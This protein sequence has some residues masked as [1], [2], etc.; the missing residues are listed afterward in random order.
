LENAQK[1]DPNSPETLLGLGYFQYMV[2]R[3]VTLA[4]TTFERVSKMLPG[5]IEV[6][7]ALANVARAEGHWDQSIAYF[8][9]A[10]ALDPR[11]VEL[12][13]RAT[14]N[15]AILRQFPAALKLLDRVLDITPNDLDVMA[16]K[17]SIYHAQGNL[18]EAAKLLSGINEQTPNLVTF[19]RKITQLQYERNYGEAIRLLQARLAQFH[20]DSE[21]PKAGDQLTLALTQRLAGDT[22]TAKVTAEK[23]RNTFEQLSRDQPNDANLAMAVAGAYAVMGEKDPSLKLAEKAITLGGH[24]LNLNTLKENLAEIHALVGEHSR[25][26]STLTDLLQTFYWPGTSPPITPALLRLDPVWDSLRS[27]PAF[28]KLC[29]EKKDLTTNGH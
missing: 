11:N 20:Y 28:Q 17:A 3:D 26:I 24:P 21:L 9:Q 13:E 19:G 8:E 5:S 15:Y 14:W 18:P 6:R 7:M 1:L 12:L 10:L 23:A 25:S 27:D 29:G 16:T 4:K 2:L 22:A